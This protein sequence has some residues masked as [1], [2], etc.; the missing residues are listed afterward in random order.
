MKY[1]KFNVQKGRKR[2]RKRSSKK[3]N[4]FPRQKQRD[5]AEGKVKFAPRTTHV[6]RYVTSR[7]TRLVVAPGGHSYYT[8]PRIRVNQMEGLNN[9][10]RMKLVRL[11]SHRATQC[12]PL[13]PP[14]PAKTFFPSVARPAI[15]MLINVPPV[16]LQYISI[17]QCI[18]IGR[19]A[20]L[21]RIINDP[22]H[23]PSS[24]VNAS[25]EGLA[26]KNPTNRVPPIEIEPSCR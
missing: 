2:R 24:L 3:S 17:Q 4:K 11:A 1:N 12:L 13:P 14:P 25:G 26:D 15:N 22:T 18:L 5:T 19:E 8:S 20:L 6:A 16:N 10:S 23:Q 21:Q 7:A 9:V